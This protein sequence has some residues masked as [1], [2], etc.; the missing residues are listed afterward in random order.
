MLFDSLGPSDDQP[1]R[2]SRD[3]V[4]YTGTHDNCPLSQW[5]EEATPER[6]AFAK[7]YMG[8]NGEEG[9]IWGMIRSGMSS[10]SICLW[11]R[12]RIIWS[13]VQNRG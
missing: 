8:L 6:V 11:R 10:V 2:Y 12:C 3:S 5:L 9:P 1:H 7:Q 13:W 4:C